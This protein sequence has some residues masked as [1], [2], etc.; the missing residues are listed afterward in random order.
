MHGSDDDAAITLIWDRGNNYTLPGH[1]ACLRYIRD[2]GMKNLFPVPQTLRDTRSSH[3]LLFPQ[4]AE[5]FTS[6][7]TP[8]SVPC[9]KVQ[10]SADSD[11]ACLLLSTSMSVTGHDCGGSAEMTAHCHPSWEIAR[12]NGICPPAR[13]GWAG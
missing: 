10:G 11:V 4:D 8:A 9:M 6:K 13:S 5:P 7:A 2:Q 1:M 3:L 12:G